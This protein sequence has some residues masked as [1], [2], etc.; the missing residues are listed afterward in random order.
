MKNVPSL[1]YLIISMGLISCPVMAEQ[2]EIQETMSEQ[3]DKEENDVKDVLV[4]QAS[5]DDIS[6]PEVITSEEIRTGTIGN[7]NVTDLLKTL[8]AVQMSNGG[9]SGNQQG[10]IKPNK[11]T[12]RG[13]NSYQN[14]FMLDGISFNNDFDPSSDG[15]GVTSTTIESSEQ[16]FYIDSRLI[17]N[18]KVYDNNI[19]VEYGNFTGGVVDI[20]SKRWRYNNGGSIFFSS[21]RSA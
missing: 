13:A 16:G 20:T 21:T 11:I 19:P 15:N 14:N 10:E 8:P 3:S 1:S 4:I 5:I 17:D 9:M 7:G 6:K 2:N 18:I 12:I